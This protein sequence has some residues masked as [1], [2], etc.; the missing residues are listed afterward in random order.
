M[1][2]VIDS[3]DHSEFG[4]RHLD[5]LKL[6]ISENETDDLSAR[7]VDPSDDVAARVYCAGYRLD[8]VGVLDDFK[9][10]RA[11]LADWI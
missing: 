6:L 5:Q 1:T 10:V 4:S 11:K 9:T 3:P 7:Q 2:L 8:R